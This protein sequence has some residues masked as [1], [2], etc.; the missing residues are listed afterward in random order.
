MS[1]LE[2]NL[3]TNTS[4]GSNNILRKQGMVPGIL[5]GGEEKNELI[6]VS[7]KNLKV[8]LDQENF[9]SNVLK[10]KINEKVIDVLPRDVSFDVVT[11]EPIHVDF[12]RMVE[13]RKKVQ[14][15]FC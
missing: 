14:F 4:R 15:L 11:D 2:V 7:K 5:Y 13:G 12:L 10:I 8:L 3:R 6:S 1:N 9:L